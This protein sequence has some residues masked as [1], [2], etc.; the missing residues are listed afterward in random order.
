MAL[1]DTFPSLFQ[2]P[3]QSRPECLLRT[4][5]KGNYHYT[6]SAQHIFAMPCWTKVNN[7][8]T[9]HYYDFL[10]FLFTVPGAFDLSDNVINSGQARPQPQEGCWNYRIMH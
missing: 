9:S 2:H 3:V 1:C 7:R 10:K 5:H 6:T 4:Q 8:S